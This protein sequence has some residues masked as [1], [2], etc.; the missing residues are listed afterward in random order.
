M[1]FSRFQLFFLTA[2]IAMAM[3]ALSQVTPAAQG[4]GFGTTRVFAEFTAGRP[5]YEDEFLVGPTIGGYIQLNRWIAGEARG[6]VLKWGPS[7]Y[8]QDTALFG[9]R[10]QLPGHRITPYAA[11]DF[12]IAHVTYPLA[13]SQPRALTSSNESA[14]QLVAGADYRLNYRWSLRLGEFTYGKINVLQNGLNPKTF[15][16]GIVFRVF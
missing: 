15:S 12:G 14:W 16:S 5:N 2:S 7:A 1:K 10:V 8:H 3:P 4:G 11:F 9:P 13:G 6:S